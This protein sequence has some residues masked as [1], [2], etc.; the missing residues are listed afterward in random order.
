MVNSITSPGRSDQLSIAVQY[1]C[2]GQRSNHS[3]A[4]SLASPRGST[5]VS[6]TKPSRGIRSFSARERSSRFFRL[7][8]G[9][10]DGVRK[11]R[12]SRPARQRDLT[13]SPGRLGIEATKDESFG[14]KAAI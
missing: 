13:L 12:N 10:R 14:G 3:R 9:G 11:R 8:R 5:K 2:L 4:F 1:A 7:S 6:R